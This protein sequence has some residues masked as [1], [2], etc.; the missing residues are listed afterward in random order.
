MGSVVGGHKR[1]KRAQR[2]GES[3]AGAQQN[4]E[5]EGR[6]GGKDLRVSLHHSADP[7]LH[8]QVVYSIWQMIIKGRVSGRGGEGGM[9]PCGS[10]RA[11]MV[12]TLQLVL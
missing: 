2:D 10:T 11:M 12:C 6:G 9:R 8:E 7:N 4:G 1:G 5:Q 3:A